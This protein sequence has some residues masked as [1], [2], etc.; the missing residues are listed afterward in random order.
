M[1]SIAAWKGVAVGG[2]YSAS[3]F[4]LEGSI[5]SLQ[6]EIAPCGINVHLVV[7]LQFRTEILAANR[8]KSGRGDNS[9]H[10]Y[11]ATVEAFQNRL[12]QTNGTQP[13]DPVQAV[14][15]ILDLVCR[16]GYFAGQQIFRYGL[17]SGPM[18]WES[19]E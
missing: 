13:R 10:E 1:S 7:L 17:F 16:R 18:Q 15:R 2:P 6:K 4:A 19:F 5:E 8:R 9:I 14:E 3:K 12:E 11:D